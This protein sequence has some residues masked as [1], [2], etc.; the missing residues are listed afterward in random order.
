MF[1]KGIFKEII[2]DKNIN[3]NEVKFYEGHYADLYQNT[4]KTSSYD[5]EVYQK[6]AA[7]VG[8]NILELAC[9]S[10][11]VG[12]SLA[13]AGYNVTGIDISED[14]LNIYKERLSK[15]AG[16][17]KNRVRIMQGDITNFS[18]G[19]KF[20]LIILPAITICLF[21]DEQ[22][23]KILK[24]VSE[25]LTENGRFA[26]DWVKYEADRFFRNCTLPFTIRWSN[27]DT[28]NIVLIQ[29]FLI[30]ECQEIL[31]NMYGEIIRGNETIRNIGYT[32]KRIITQEILKNN[33]DNSPLKLQNIIEIQ[34][35]DYEQG[36]IFYILGK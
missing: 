20:D 34:N 27:E 9:G 5:I 30:P 28:Y 17:V 2:E 12:I 21:N 33:I 13:K 4:V 7:W 35:S 29:E 32:K 24:C 22:I 1:Y 26:F 11:R 6:Q 10:G 36:F 23:Q 16:R 25:H 31:V 19:E 18:V 8:R 3:V 15:E 14:M